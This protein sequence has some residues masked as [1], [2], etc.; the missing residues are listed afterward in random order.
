MIRAKNKRRQ[1]NKLNFLS[2]FLLRFSFLVC[3]FIIFGGEAKPQII[4]GTITDEQNAPVVA[5]EIS[6]L[7]QN[8]TI[9]RL[10]SDGE[11]KFSLEGK[12][13]PNL[14]LRVSAKG[15]ALFERQLNN[16]NSPLTIVLS[17][18]N[19]R[20]EVTVSITRTE[21]RL[22]ET[23]AS[24]VVLDRETLET[25][26]AQ[27][28]DE[29]LRQV[30]GFGLFR[31]SSSRTT[32]P[33]AQGANFRGL[34]GSGAS[35][36]AV[37]FDGLSLNDAFGGWT[38]W[39]R[40]PRAAVE[41]IEVLRG[42]ASAF[43]G[44]SALSGAVNF[45]TLKPEENAPILRFETSVG[46][47]ATFDGSLFAAYA[48]SG[49]GFDLAAESFKTDGYIP[50]VETERGAADAEADS[51]HNNMFL[52]VNRNFGEAARIFARGNYFTENRNNGTLLQY[53][54]TRFRQAAFGADFTNE[55]IGA[56]Q[57]RSFIETQVYDQTFTAVSADRNT[58]TLSRIQ[59]VPSQA[60][61]ASLFWNQS[62]FNHAVAASFE[63]RQVRGFSN[64]IGFFGGRATSLNDSGGRE[65]TFSIFAQEIW[66]VSPKL[67]LNFGARFDSW[68]NFDAL[69]LAK[70]IVTNH[71]VIVKFSDRN[72]SA[73][74]PRVA[75][76]YRINRNFSFL[77]SYAKSFRA[78]TLN[79]LYRAFRVGNVATGANENLRAE[80]AD[81]FETGLNF[82]G[83]AQK[84]NFR[85]NFFITEVKN[86]VVSV[87]LTTTPGLITRQRQNVGKTRARGVEFDAEYA[88]R[89]DLRFSASYLFVDSRVTEFPGNPELTGKFLPQ[90]PRQQFT[91]QTA[92]RPQEKLS[93]GFQGRISAAQFEDDLNTLRLHSYFTLDAF[94]AYRLP[95]NLEIFAA[96][97]NVFNNRY[98]IGR[99]PVLTV[100]APR[101]ARVGL[102][103]NLQNK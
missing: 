54:Q 64:E 48:K 35:R 79:E 21:T 14:I 81:T 85:G 59:R 96:A 16:L 100:A 36:A 49:W 5:A 93:L 25:T 28:P 23:P 82:T 97:E 69:N 20:E 46:T 61:G 50:I 47:Q 34:A 22:A 76:L 90:I 26:A 83:F 60:T 9:S 32:N 13:E 33:T 10:T 51:R 78:P 68:K 77:A 2:S 17:P 41:Q 44:N 74:S 87:T 57:L 8:K 1:S 103:F 27:T 91:F 30:A 92:Y 95:K 43:Y 102:R 11:G 42:G 80:R 98:D 101:F 63:F 66:R 53:N 7:S 45:L 75:A 67:N 24:V 73:F 62:F 89:G 37:L 3:L 4:S 38:Y 15:F 94:A 65:R 88:P 29:I 12:G 56:F 40:V 31:R 58:E 39:S 99:T 70:S 72:E 71:A 55:K 19:L 52:T 18:A 86:P 84:L 6:L